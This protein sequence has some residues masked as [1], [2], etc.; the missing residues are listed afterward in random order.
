M[1]LQ[2]DSKDFKTAYS[3]FFEA[4]EA[5]DEKNGMKGTSAA[6]TAKASQC[7]KCV[8]M[9]CAPVW[10]WLVG[11]LSGCVF[12]CDAFYVLPR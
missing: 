9:R 7:L 1:L 12:R 6:Q 10:R 3:Y 8:A 11:R 2:A 5:H 4:F